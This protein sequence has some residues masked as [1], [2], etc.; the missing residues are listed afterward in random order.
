[1]AEVGFAL[2][3]DLGTS[4]TVAVLRWPDGRTRPL[5]VDGAPL[6]PSGVYADPAGKLHVGRD[7]LRLA[8][9]DPARF[10]PNPKRRI[11]EQSVLLGDREVLT[12]DL[13]AALLAA[14][15]NAAVEAVGH[16]PPAVLTYPAS[17]GSARRAT[18]AA[19]A[20]RA[21]WP[22]PRLVPEP[23][24]AARYFA[25][26]LRRPI[27]AGGSLAVFDFGG[28][29]LDIAVVRNEGSGYAVIGSGGIEDLGGLDIDAALVDNLGEVIA[30]TSPD[31]WQALTEP[32]TTTERRDRRLFWDDV[33]GAKEMLSR[34]T[35][36]PVAVPRREEAL[37]LTRE[38]LERT[39]EPL[40]RRA[41]YETGEVI[42]RCG[43]RPDQ[44][45]GLFLVGGS[46][47][48]PL[49]ARLL[50]SQLGIAPTVLE[51]PELPVAE[52]ALAEI[53]PAPATSPVTPV[54][55][56]A[57]VPV[58]P[59]APFPVSPAAY[60]STSPVSPAPLSPPL[61]PAAPVGRG[62]WL[63]RPVWITAVAAVLV[64]ALVAAV[65]WVWLRDPVREVTF[66][67]LRAGLELEA[68]DVYPYGT[69]RSVTIGDRAYVSWSTED[70]ELWLAAVNLVGDGG[71]GSKLWARKV[72]GT[73]Q[74]WAGL[75]AVPGAVVAYADDY[76]NDPA[77]I[78]VFSPTSG[79]ELWRR[80]LGDNDPIW[81]F[82]SL[83][84]H[85]DEEAG[86]LRGLEWSNQRVKWQRE[87]PTPDGAS[88]PES[89]FLR[90]VATTDQFRGPSLMGVG[91]SA[92]SPSGTPRLVQIGASSKRAWLIDA[93]NGTP[94]RDWANV[95]GSSDLYYAQDETLYVASYSTPYEV[96]A[97]DLGSDGEPATLYTS[98]DTKRRWETM[99]QCGEKRLCILDTVSADAKST[100]ILLID[101]G[102]KKEVRRMAA[103]G[104]DTLLQ[105]GDH[106][107]ATNLTGTPSSVLYDADGKQ[108]L[109][110]ADKIALG[111]RVNAASLLL[112]S[113][114]VNEYPEN[115]NLVGRSLSGERV[116]AGPL[117]DVRGASCSWNESH[118]VCVHKTHVKVWRF[119]DE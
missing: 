118:L 26:V 5:L 75:Y 25:N 89:T 102:A 7:A 82:D 34:A 65:A 68:T 10:E 99:T 36:A 22:P 109:A 116:S 30:A 104:T 18:L 47:R 29:T 86:M 63:R 27:P 54:S 28:G 35:V 79:D 60:A 117:V 108:M 48:L 103:P 76:S 45:A 41:V 17:W 73:A 100:Q 83:L 69:A 113:E 38:E 64:A 90:S 105:F 31:R 39:G 12:V 94:I 55:G 13:L 115:V 93:N 46:S 67:T 91:W 16:L 92:D 37:H 49:V 23:V 106:I 84:V 71:N 72:S 70:K 2:G 44:L 32:T 56:S 33:R 111:V 6:M 1:M 53:A 19:G 78:I 87:D 114:Q 15:A 66:E 85:Y 98:R 110:D 57:P 74:K 119:T 107:L 77:K 112:F 11:D 58:S 62:P 3:V 42:A 14:V 95:G 50:H 97:Y 59:G 43:L 81:L 80:N 101:V 40:V 9:L 24:A 20:Q 96:R 52:G 8:Q 4:N 51:Q 21:G 88:E 61:S